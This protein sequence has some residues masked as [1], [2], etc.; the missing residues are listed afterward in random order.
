MATGR[1]DR[2]LGAVQLLVEGDNPR[3]WAE[4]RD[5]LGLVVEVESRGDQASVVSPAA[6]PHS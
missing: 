2:L 1:R 4:A 5:L 3:L 6:S